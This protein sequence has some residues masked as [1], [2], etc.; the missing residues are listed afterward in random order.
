LEGRVSVRNMSIE[1]GAG[2]GIVA[3]DYTAFAWLEARPYAPKD[4]LWERAVDEWRALA[5]DADAALDREVTIDATTLRPCVTWGTNPA[6]SVTIDQRVPD[7]E[8]YR[9]DGQRDSASR[10]LRYQDLR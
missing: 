5:T 10:A 4:E 9:E 3:A 8:S 6:Q 7:P 1:A 2:A